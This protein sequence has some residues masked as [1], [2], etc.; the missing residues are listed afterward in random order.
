MDT[1]LPNGQS[2]SKLPEE[3]RLSLF[4]SQTFD[5]ID[6]VLVAAGVSDP[7][8]SILSSELFFLASGEHEVDVFVKEIMQGYG[9]TQDQA[10]EV[11][12]KVIV[13][14]LLPF[15]EVLSIPL[16]E[17]IQRWQPT[18]KEVSLDDNRPSVDEDRAQKR[19]GVVKVAEAE[20]V[21]EVAEVGSIEA[22]KPVPVEPDFSVEEQEAA[23]INKEKAHI[24]QE[25]GPL[26]IPGIV[27][28][29]CQNQA[30][31]LED[32]MLRG[33]C[34]KIVESRVRDVRD[35]FAARGALEKPVEQG[36]VGISGRRL[37]DMV[38]MLESLVQTYHKNLQDQQTQEREATTQQ[39]PTREA[40]AK[41]EENLLS[42]RYIELTGRMPQERVAPAAPSVS[43]TSAAISAHHEQLQRE[44]K[45]DAEKV[46]SVVEQSKT[47]AVKRAPA[48]RPSMQEVTFQ[49]RLHGPTEELKTL[50]LA[51]FRRMSKDP[52]QA[53]TK[54]KDKVDLLEDQGYDK[55]VEAIQAWRS[56][57]MNQMYVA[58]TRDTVLKGV[59][60]QEI[61]S[62]KRQ[63]GEE[64]FTDEELKAVMKLN[65]D[66]RF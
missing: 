22:P 29:I 52:L 7:D 61:L 14:S 17:M 6:E 26:D 46:K 11:A 56:S 25:Q 10:Q 62:Q 18:I 36:G 44:G 65:A 3:V 59:P 9:L 2:I 15:K 47:Q 50:S 35:A 19:V 57:P 39:Q 13:K 55:K 54:V 40:L 31:Q 5:F 37:A 27:K 30:F 49:K 38:Q 4:S 32:E 28:E 16:E 45:I 23:R 1:H 8:V 42:K 34:E 21:D 58:L 12:H 33:R 66:L 41:N 43:R 24:I 60:L 63:A 53:A 64:I 20:K 51:D 48:G